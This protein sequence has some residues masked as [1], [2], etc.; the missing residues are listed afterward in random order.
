MTTN[1]KIVLLVTVLIVAGGVDYAVLTVK[2]SDNIAPAVEVATNTGVPESSPLILQGTVTGVDASKMQVYLNASTTNQL[3]VATISQA[4]KI[5]KIISQKNAKG[6]VE[7]QAL[8]EVNIDDVQKG[9]IVTVVYQ[10]EKD[11]VLSGVSRITF[12]V[13]GNIDAYFKSQAESRTPYLKGQ[14]VAMDIAG[15]TL[16]YKPVMFDTISTTTMSIAIPDGISVY[17]VDDSLRTS[18]IHARTAASLT[19]IQPNQTIFIKAD[20][21]S[22]KTGKVVPQALIISGK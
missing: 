20:V 8:I 17:R 21:A 10:S 1:I 9:N 4:T 18:I 13:D 3:K 22:L 2:P 16:Q 11:G 5:E 12:V 15:K 7:K 6:I 19:D 14:V